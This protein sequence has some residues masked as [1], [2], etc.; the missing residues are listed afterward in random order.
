MSGGDLAVAIAAAER[1]FEIAESAVKVAE[2]AA[3]EVGR[4]T[5]LADG[6]RDAAMRFF[7]SHNG[8]SHQCFCE[9]CVPVRR[10]LEVQATSSM[11][12]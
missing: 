2:L 11:V 8:W 5:G 9:R 12:E 4:V 1:A 7:I 10:L 3:L 6:W